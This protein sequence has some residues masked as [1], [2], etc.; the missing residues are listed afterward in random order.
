M[1]GWT[2]AL[3]AAA[4]VF[5]TGNP[6]LAAVHK[7]LLGQAAQRGPR[8]PTIDRKPQYITPELEIISVYCTDDWEL[9][10]TVR[11]TADQPAVIHRITISVLEDNGAGRPAIR[12]SATYDVHVADLRKGQSGGIQVSHFVEPRGVDRFKIALHTTR[13][14]VLRLT[15]D[16]NKGEKTEADVGVFDQR[17]PRRAQAAK[18]AVDEF[19]AA[20]RDGDP[21]AV[22]CAL[23]E[24]LHLAGAQ[25][26]ELAAENGHS[27]VVEALL[28]HRGPHPDPMVHS[29]VRTVFPAKTALL[30]AA[31]RGHVDVVAMLLRH[32]ADIRDERGQTSL[33]LAAGAGHVAVVELLLARGAR[34]DPVAPGKTALMQAA[35]RGHATVLTA[36]LQHGADVN[37]QDQN[38]QTALIWA[39]CQ[40]QVAI[41]RQLLE[42]GA[43]ACIKDRWGNTAVSLAAQQRR[44]ELVKLLEKS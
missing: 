31:E 20:A 14:L 38:G 37:F 11:N 28:A 22:G 40:N 30:R 21:S 4:H 27:A 44:S 10:V 1:E 16:Y 7:E 35:T 42:A 8:V 2:G 25:A 29:K 39:I 19:V 17:K 26:L 32:G 3:L 15:L 23:P 9:D 36:L 34:P 13:D 43:N 24:V 12:P 41:M 33:D 18:A 6:K 5:N